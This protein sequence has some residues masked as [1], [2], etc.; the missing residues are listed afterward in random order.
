MQRDFFSDR[1]TRFFGTDRYTVLPFKGLSYKLDEKSGIIIRRLMYPVSDMNVP[2]LC[3]HFI[4]AVYGTVYLVPTAVPAFGREN[5][6]DLKGVKFGDST[7]ILFRLGK[8]YLF[9][10][11]GFRTFVHEE[12]GRFLK[13]QFAQAAHALVP[14]LEGSHLLPCQKVGI[15]AQLLDKEKGELVMYFLVEQGDSSTHIL[16]AV[17]PA[18]TSSISFAKYVFNQSAFI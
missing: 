4:K 9:G 18:F 7:A 17:S 14:C 1:I 5:Y 2:F 3:V 15:R 13:R 16:N 11:Q 12:A 10:R 6:R 8:Q